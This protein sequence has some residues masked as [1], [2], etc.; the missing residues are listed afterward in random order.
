MSKCGR[1]AVHPFEGLNQLESQCPTGLPCSY[2]KSGTFAIVVPVVVVVIVVAVGST[3]ASHMAATSER[4]L[5][6]LTIESK[7]FQVQNF[8]RTRRVKCNQMNKIE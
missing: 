7:K 2:K 4:H 8:A 3:R 5:L 6:H 1:F